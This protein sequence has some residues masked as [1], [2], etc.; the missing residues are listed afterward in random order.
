MTTHHDH[1]VQQLAV[2]GK[3]LAAAAT[4]GTAAFIKWVEEANVVIDAVAGTVAIVAGLC[5]I[6]WYGYR[7]IK[8]RGGDNDQT[9]S[10]E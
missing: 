2:E 10:S 9:D 4:T 7:F 5:T 1:V 6:A 3:G 8:L